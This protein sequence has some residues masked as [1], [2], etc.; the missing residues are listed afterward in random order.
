MPRAK[1]RLKLRAGACCGAARR[2]FQK[3]GMVIAGEPTLAQR[4]D[5]LPV[6]I[7]RKTGLLSSDAEIIS[8]QFG[9]A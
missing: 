5:G 7:F 6:G 3:T 9:K 1:A 4:L 2:H 8:A